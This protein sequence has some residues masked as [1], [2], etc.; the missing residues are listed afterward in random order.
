MALGFDVWVAA[1]DRSRP[2]GDG[3]LSDHCLDTLP[4]ALASQ[5]GVETVKLID[6]LWIEK[7][8]GRAAAAFEV[9]HSTSIYSGIVRLLDLAMSETSAATQVLFLVA[10]DGRADEVRA[11]LARPAFRQVRNLNIRFLPYGEL[12]SHRQTAAR[13]GEGL[14]AILAISEAMT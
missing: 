6:V 9:E 1:N 5:A 14:K 13:F 4:T 3:R 8:G 2:F 7:D 10:P 11:Q 12:E